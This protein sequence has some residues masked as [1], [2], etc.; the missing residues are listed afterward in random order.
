MSG[1]LRTLEKI[2]SGREWVQRAKPEFAIDTSSVSRFFAATSSALRTGS[3]ER[4]A[5]ELA[6][7]ADQ[8]LRPGDD[9]LAAHEE[10]D[11]YS[12]CSIGGHRIKASSHEQE[13]L[14]KVRALSHIYSFDLRTHSLHHVALCEPQ[15]GKKKEH[16][17]A[18]LK[19]IDANAMRMGAPRA[20]RLS[21]PT[22]R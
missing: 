15:M 5:A 16:E 17:I 7:L 22:T 8:S 3:V 11:R 4:T 13:I 6:R 19:R 10:L 18:T 12:V 2:E 21:T 14:G 1:T 20:A 9:I